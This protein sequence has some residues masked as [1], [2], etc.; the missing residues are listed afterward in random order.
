MAPAA[1][2]SVSYGWFADFEAKVRY[3]LGVSD[4]R[5]QL[6]NLL[7][8]HTARKHAPA[9]DAD[10]FEVFGIEGDDASEF[11]EAFAAQ[12]GVDMSDYRWYF[13]HSEEGQNVGSVFFHPPDR[14]VQ[15]IPITMHLLL[16]AIETKQWP[17]HYPEHV[18]PRVRW[19]VRFNQLLVLLFLLALA[20][21]LW[22]RFVR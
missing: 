4:A 15:R 20:S 19:D 21:W 10:L 9:D 11:M 22:S 8:R 16:E 5:T 13:H 1:R 17:V 3:P 2:L 6:S 18:L 14:R 7:E 12:F